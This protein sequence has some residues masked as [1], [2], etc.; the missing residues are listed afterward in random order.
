VIHIGLSQQETVDIM[1]LIAHLDAAPAPAEANR[2][3]RPRMDFCHPM[4]MNLPT[5][6]GQPWIHV[7]SR[8]LSTT[9]LAFLVRRPFAIDEY[10]VIA[11]HLNEGLA[12]LALC[13][14]KYCR[15]V[16]AAVFEVGLEFQAMAPDPDN[17][18][19]IPARWTALVH[20]NTWI[21]RTR[22]KTC[23]PV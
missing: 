22:A 5:E 7:F 18:R 1:D 11:H 3:S 8:N 2:R 21:S 13:N 20:R 19:R 12:Q 17:M 14:V 6:P 4:W 10:L 15:P 16:T 9:G 23:V